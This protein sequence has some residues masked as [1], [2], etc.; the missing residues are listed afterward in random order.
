MRLV[1]FVSR[2]CALRI[3]SYRER[4]HEDPFQAIFGPLLGST[5]S[6]EWV[7]PARKSHLDFRGPPETFKIQ[8]KPGK[9]ILERTINVIPMIS[10]VSM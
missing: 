1:G 5:F 8:E 4:I 2:S 6:E 7:Q 3:N 10:Y 9:I